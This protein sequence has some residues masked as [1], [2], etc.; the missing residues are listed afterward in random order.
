MTESTLI[1]F[2][3]LLGAFGAWSITKFGRRLGLMDRPNSRSSH[4]VPTPK[5]GGVGLLAAFLL[6]A[7]WLNISAAFWLP[8]AAVSLVGL[9]ADRINIGPKLRL[10][11]HFLA[12]FLLVLSVFHNPEA[13]IAPLLLIPF[14]AIFIV[15][16]ANFY[17]FMDGINGISAITGTVAFGLITLKLILSGRSDIY[18]VLSGSMVAACIGFLPLNLVKAKVFMGD[19]GSILLGFAFAGYV[20]AYTSDL[21][22]FICM[23]AF[24]IPFYIDELT[25]MV[26]RIKD[27][28]HLFEPH[29]RHVNQLLANEGGIA[30]WKVSCGYGLL[31]L[32][33]GLSILFAFRSSTPLAVSLFLF[34]I[35]ALSI[36]SFLLRR[37]YEQPL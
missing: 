4:D 12:A 23:T 3:L 20:F 8:L 14:W 17:N 31:Q 29:R 21:T 7:F 16:T 30:H 22:D 2:C 9:L 25:T 1:I 32:F 18:A 24:L 34:Y 11:I 15:G 13:R 26:V 35:A 6:A 10:L 19:V 36:A 27:K 5:G 33:I 37:R 28:E